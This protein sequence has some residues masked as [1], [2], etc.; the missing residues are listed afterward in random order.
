MRPQDYVPQIQALCAE[1]EPGRRLSS[2]VLPDVES[3]AVYECIRAVCA[4]EDHPVRRAIA[5]SSQGASLVSEVAN[6]RPGETLAGSLDGPALVSIALAFLVLGHDESSLGA[7][8]LARSVP[9]DELEVV[10]QNTDTNP[11]TS[12]PDP[13]Q[14]ALMAYLK[15]SD[16][17]EA[18][19]AAAAYGRASSYG[20]KDEL[21]S[22]CASFLTECG[23]LLKD[24]P[25]DA[26][27]AFVACKA[28]ASTCT[29][30]RT[31]LFY[32]AA[33]RPFGVEAVAA[34]ASPLASPALAPLAPRASSSSEKGFLAPEANTGV[35]GSVDD[36]IMRALNL[37]L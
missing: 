11:V 20:S 21:A 29:S 18:L 30:P 15:G 31:R 10:W 19:L 6:I 7:R 3:T 2:K 28:D 16:S 1:L 33:E 26:P 27:A 23:V 36:M 14:L 32:E 37:S 24:G 22:V 8:R 17:A 34:V 35:D 12:D 25:P 4:D 13:V 5:A 9:A